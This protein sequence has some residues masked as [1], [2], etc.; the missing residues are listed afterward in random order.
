MKPSEALRTVET[1]NDTGVEEFIKSVRFARTRVSDTAYLLRIILTEKITDRAK[2]SIRFCQ[3]TSYEE[4]YA[5][6]RTQVSIPTTVSG[7]RNKMQNIKQGTN[8]TVQSYSDRF[9]QVLNELKYAVQ[10]KHSNPTVRNLALEEV[11]TEARFYIHNLRTDLAQCI[12]LMRPTS[13][14]EA[15]QE[16]SNM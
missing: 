9:R 5:T 16:A 8:E 14:I 7:S 6:L 15:Q 12:I 2:Q 11:N 3:I 1:F 4:L 10:E 13:L